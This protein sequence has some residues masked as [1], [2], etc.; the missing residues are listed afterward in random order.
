M[1]EQILPNEQFADIY[2]LLVKLIKGN[3]VMNA[4]GITR[5]CGKNVF[6]AFWS[7]SVCPEQYEVSICI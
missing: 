1:T 7:T 2:L 3:P 6:G 4:Q 5:V